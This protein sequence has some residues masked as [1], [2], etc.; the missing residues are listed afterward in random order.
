METVVD[1]SG[2]VSGSTWLVYVRKSRRSTPGLQLA[3]TT[4]G[5][6]YIAVM[7]I[8]ILW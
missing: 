8:N 5:L 4:H 7:N 6:T 3:K 1:A 2:N